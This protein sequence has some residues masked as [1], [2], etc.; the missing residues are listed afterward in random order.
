VTDVAADAAHTTF[1]V[2]FREETRHRLLV[3]STNGGRCLAA[4]VSVD[5]P[6]AVSLTW[7]RQ[8]SRTIGFA[9]TELLSRFE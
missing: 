1:V 4:G 8:G 6:T 2:V 3:T 5:L 7:S 9:H